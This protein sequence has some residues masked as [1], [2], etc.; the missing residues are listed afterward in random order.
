MAGG[1]CVG[2]DD[3]NGMVE[4]EEDGD[5]I[6]WGF[7]LSWFKPMAR[8]ARGVVKNVCPCIYIWRKQ[9]SKGQ[10]CIVCR[11]VLMYYYHQQKLDWTSYFLTNNC[12]S[13]GSW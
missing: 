3:R 12:V 4:R 11:Y 6:S 10:N 1:S 7:H 5:G 8:P 9:L 13:G 2:S